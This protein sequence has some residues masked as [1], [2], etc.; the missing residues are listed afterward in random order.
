MVMRCWDLFISQETKKKKRSLD[1]L[2]SSFF[3]FLFRI[4]SSSSSYIFF[5]NSYEFRYLGVSVNNFG[6]RMKRFIHRL[7]NLLLQS[8]CFSLI[9]VLLWWWDNLLIWSHKCSPACAISSK[10]FGWSSILAGICSFVFD[11]FKFTVC[12]V[13]FAW[14]SYTLRIILVF[15][16]LFT[17]IESHHLFVHLCII[18]IYLLCSSLIL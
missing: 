5:S 4:F 6:L 7:C 1:H 2:H 15:I 8:F 12:L 10:L 3:H 13:M 11:D 18:E 9:L 16:C 17:S 14:I